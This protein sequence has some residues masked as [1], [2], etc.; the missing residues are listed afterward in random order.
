MTD[1]TL[2][3]NAVIEGVDL[4]ALAEWMETEGFSGAEISNAQILSGGSQNILVRFEKGG[5]EFVLRR[6]PLAK[7]GNSDETMNRE[8]RVLKA[9]QGSPVP[10][11]GFIANCEH[12]DVLGACFYL[13]E[14]IEGFNPA[15]GLPA[16][17]QGDANMRHQMG[18]NLVRAIA[19]LGELDYQAIGLEGFGKPEGY[20]AR[21]AGRWRKQL[22]AYSDLQAYPGPDIPGLDQVSYWLE[23]QLPKDYRPGVIHG[24]CHIANVMFSRH[25]AEVAA[26]VD[27]ELSTIGDPLLDLGWILATSPDESGDRSGPP[28]WASYP[29]ATELI[30]SYAEISTRNLD[31]LN[32]YEVLA[33][34]KL[35]IILEGSYARACAGKARQS[36]GDKFHAITRTL[37]RRAL[38][39]ISA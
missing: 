16:L 24:D 31:A 11:P 39:R 35:G 1:K 21:Q 9:L 10:H 34:Y 4:N 2:G 8:A 14:P 32:W 33:C 25:D 23:D 6:P 28:P 36:T 13:M 5:R 27:W 3:K 7:R 37:F 26:L 19:R 15:E 20:L 18:L 17:H 12:M 30:A 22:D 29:S 38:R